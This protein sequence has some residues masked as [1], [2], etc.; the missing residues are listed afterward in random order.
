MC[1]SSPSNENAIRSTVED[2][3][4]QHQDSP[5]QGHEA[6]LKPVWIALAVTAGLAG[7]LLLLEIDPQDW[8]PYA[9]EVLPIAYDDWGTLLGGIIAA[10]LVLLIVP[11]VLGIRAIRAGREAAWW[12][13]FLALII[14]WRDAAPWLDL[15]ASGGRAGYRCPRA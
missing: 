12:P 2:V 4:K 9:W 1:D 6:S 10:L 11:I 13:T 7:T 15:R 3:S 14:F 8:F 5:A